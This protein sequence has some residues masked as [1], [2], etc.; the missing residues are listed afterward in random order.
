[1]KKRLEELKSK[2]VEYE[3][4]YMNEYFSNEYFGIDARDE[5]GLK[6]AGKP[7]RAQYLKAKEHQY[8]TFNE[9]LYKVNNNKDATEEEIKTANLMVKTAR[10]EVQGLYKLFDKEAHPYK[11]EIAKLEKS[12]ELAMQTPLNQMIS[13]EEQFAEMQRLGNVDEAQKNKK[14]IRKC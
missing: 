12:I 5:K 14:K 3:K 7:T 11:D 8:S 4:K 1:M 9:Q 13:L 2:Q 10:R 6:D